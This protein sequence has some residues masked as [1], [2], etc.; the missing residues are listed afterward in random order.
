MICF[1]MI[2]FWGLLIIAWFWLWIFLKAPIT[3]Y[4]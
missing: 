3:T 4:D 1:L 2:F